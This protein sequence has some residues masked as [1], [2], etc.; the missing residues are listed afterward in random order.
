MIDNDRTRRN[1]NWDSRFLFT[2]TDGNHSVRLVSMTQ[3]NNDLWV[4]MK[5]GV[6]TRI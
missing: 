1:C 4:E 5:A 3:A 2:H 6:K